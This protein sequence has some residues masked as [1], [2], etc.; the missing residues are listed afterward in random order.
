MPDLD[1]DLRPLASLLAHCGARI[2]ANDLPDLLRGVTAAPIGHDPDAWMRLVARDPSPELRAM[3]AAA[4]DRTRLAAPADGRDHAQRLAALRAEL[5]RR[6]LTGMIVPR[7]DEHL[8]EYVA[9]RSERL[10]WLTGFTGSAGTAV[11]LHERAALFVDGRYTT[12]AACEVDD[13]SFIVRHSTHEP[14]AEWLAE[15]LP[16]KAQLGYDAWLH[17]PHQ[18]AALTKACAAGDAQPVPLDD[19]PIDRVWTDQPP[20]PLAPVV[21]HPEYFAGRPSGEKRALVIET[22]RKDGQ[23]AVVLTQPDAIAWLLNIRGGDV[24]FTPLPL[25]FAMVEVDGPAQLFID[26]RKLTDEAFDQLGSSVAVAPV[27]ALGSTLDRLAAAGKKVRIDPDATPDWVVRRLRKAGGVIAEADDPCALPK[28][29]KTPPELAGIRNAHRRDGAALTRFLAKLAASGLADGWTE[30]DAAECLAECRA[31]NEHYRGPSFPTISAAS[32]HGAIVHYR[33]SPATN[34]ALVGGA[35][36]LVDSGAQYLDGTTDVTRT[37]ALGEPSAEMR[38]RF[39]LVLKGHIALANARFPR[40]TTG[41]QLDGLAR[42]P[43]WRA[44]LDYDHGTGHGVG[45]YLSVHEGPQRISKLPSR[46]ALQPGMVIS[47]E[48]GYYKPNDYGIRIENLVT[49]IRLETP[50][51]AEQELLGFETLTLA[52]I[53]RALIDKDLMTGEE[54]AW[55]D[56][57]HARV[58][59]ALAPLVDDQT[60]TWL[61]E[62]TRPL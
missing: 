15:F 37:I 5:R 45:N 46:I 42:A 40:G 23:G 56:R 57:Y 20:Q 34:Q 62:V 24:P 19:N 29:V 36:F 49:V 12:Q 51:G 30:I 47:N 61:T 32:E 39:T 18:A 10:A 16:S 43:L 54:V 48:P 41:S 14:L 52:P 59:G 22:L 4:L 26:A 7:G 33:V 58:H 44:G 2:D 53:D 50:L 17:T 38:Q 31:S 3:L 6:R 9:A 1:V 25:S 11:V 13:R 60:R 28:A 21:P 27:E 8:G 35:L 55:L